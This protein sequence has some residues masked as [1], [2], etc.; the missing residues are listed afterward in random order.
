MIGRI[1]FVDRQNPNR[2][3][4]R[5]VA[6]HID[7]VIAV[8]AVVVAAIVVAVVGQRFPSNGENGG[9]DTQQRYVTKCIQYSDRFD[10]TQLRLSPNA[11]DTFDR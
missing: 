8:T 7:F 10:E 3:R 2:G 11:T 6:G 4:K 9:Y 5:R 1:G